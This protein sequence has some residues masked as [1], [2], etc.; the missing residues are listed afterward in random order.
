MIGLAERARLG[1]L[2]AHAHPFQ[3][4]AKMSRVDEE[5][6]TLL[7]SAFRIALPKA[8]HAMVVFGK[9]GGASGFAFLPGDSRLT[10]ITSTKW[11]SDPIR[12]VPAPQARRGAGE[13]IY[14]RQRILLGSE[15]QNLL[16]NATIGVVG[17]GGGGS[18][19]V[20]Q[21]TLMGVG[22]LVLVDNDK[23]EEENRHR[24][25]GGR[26][27]DS[28]EGVRKI[29]VMKRLVSESNPSVASVCCADRFPS[30]KAT[31]LLKE[32]DVLVGCVDT[33]TARKELQNFAWRY[34][35]PYVDIGLSIQVGDTTGRAQTISGQVYDL[36]PGAGC[37]W[38]AQFL[39]GDRLNA[40][41]G[42]R[43][44][45]YISDGTE[46][47]QVVS[48][49]GVLASQAACEVLHLLTGYSAR[50]KVPTA[51]QYDGIQGTL[52]PVRIERNG[53]CPVCSNELGRGDG[54]W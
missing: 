18:H 36:I 16:S 32:C 25:I 46:Q 33:L 30:D 50:V 47:A 28:K 52:S 8:P 38:C 29:E 20:Q 26:P 7:C 23:V 4:S 17:L 24:L 14:S 41:W 5:T 2:I 11:L 31:R 53:A 15:G 6:G 10:Q 27:A 19:V 44:P 35:I 45:T 42:G 1:L 48:F 13:R 40:E 39:T 43:G 3:D 12:L 37:L 54:L 21:L 34:L 22:K 49:N 51:L 9:N